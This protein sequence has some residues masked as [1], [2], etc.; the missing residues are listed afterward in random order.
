MTKGCVTTTV[1]RYPHSEH[2]ANPFVRLQTTGRL[3]DWQ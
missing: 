3:H 1:S 2:T